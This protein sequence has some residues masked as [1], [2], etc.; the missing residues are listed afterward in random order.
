MSSDFFRL[1]CCSFFLLASCEFAVCQDSQAARAPT[2]GLSGGGGGADFTELMTLI[3]QTIDPQAWLDNSS[4]MV[5]YP[6]GV[7]VDP[8]G[9]IRHLG[10]ADNVQLNESTSPPRLQ[11]GRVGH[12]WLARSEQRVV[13]LRR[14]DESLADLRAHG[15]RISQE[16]QSF[17]GMSRIDFL[18][19]D[20]A[21]EDI[22]LVGPANIPHA[23]Q[24]AVEHG[25]QLQ[26]LAL[27]TSL[28][29]SRTLPLGCSIDPTDEGIVAATQLVEAAGALKRLSSNPQKF[30]G[31]MQE[32]IGP[33]HVSIYGMPANSPTALALVVADEHMKKIGFGTAKT[34]V[35]IQ[36][37]FDHLD[38]RTDVPQQSLIRWWFTYANAPIGVNAAG[39]LFQFPKSSVALLSEQQWVSLVGR[40][41]TGAN[42]PCADA[43]AAEMTS[44][45]NELRLEHPAY[46]R[47][48]AIFESALAL[49]VALEATGQTSWEAWFPNL[50][51]AGRWTHEEA[52]TPQTVSGMTAWHKLT[53]GTTVAV[54]S[55]GVSIHARRPASRERW[56]EIE[57]PNDLPAPTT[58]T[59]RSHENWWWN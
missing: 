57:M 45:L 49:Q 21:N 19:L 30:V 55:G 54:V 22:L 36:S 59:S 38:R 14:L 51:R 7:Y 10:S 17:A 8:L 37:Y 34:N 4:T 44:K 56:Q 11:A 52:N 15:L 6:S 5:P 18:K 29:N 32:K 58:T 40:K 42:D 23:Q 46:A 1:S 20:I 25:F 13:S 39:D 31:Q 12:P 53:N 41:A 3:Q 2:S 28:V 27:L 50:V 35:S 16:M 24:T 47:M 33:H 26:D 9:Q 43:F 48:C